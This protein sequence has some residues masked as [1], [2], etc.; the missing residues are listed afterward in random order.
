MRL[1]PDEISAIK[2]A[3][4]ET[5]GSDVIVRLFGSRVDDSRRGGDIDLHLEVGALP[6]LMPR[7]RF[8]D[9]VEASTDG[10]KVDAVFS[11]RGTVPNGFE[12]I[13]YRDGLRL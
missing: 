13:A 5:F 9:I 1:Q 7:T 2:A 10:R 11:V 4:T 3:A 8:L 6:G 12:K